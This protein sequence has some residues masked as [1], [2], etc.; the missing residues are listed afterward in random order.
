MR[1][2]FINRIYAIRS[3]FRSIQYSTGYFGIIIGA[4][5]LLSL[6]RALGYDFGISY[7]RQISIFILSMT[8][9]IVVFIIALVV[10]VFMDKIIKDYRESKK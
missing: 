9:N 2:L 4:A 3:I 1:I 7:Q 10:V 5:V 8:I 6:S